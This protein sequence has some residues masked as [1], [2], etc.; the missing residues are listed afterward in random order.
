LS[1]VYAS[2]YINNR[3]KE[4]NLDPNSGPEDQGKESLNEDTQ[5]RDL[6]P[7]L[8][9]LT[10]RLVFSSA[11]SKWRGQEYDIT[12]DVVQE[13][14]HRLIEYGQKA[15]RG[16]VAPIRSY[17][18]LIPIVARNICWD[19]RRRDRRFVRLETEQVHTLSARPYD[20]ATP[21][22]IAANNV[23]REALFRLVAQRI[24]C[25]PA[26]QRK[27]LLTDLANLMYFDEEPTPLQRAFL[28]VGIQLQD[29]QQPLS[30]N[31]AERARHNA[32]LY[33]AYKRISRL[34]ELEHE[35]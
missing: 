5:W 4:V 24:A 32:L 19:G 30:A 33:Q 11:V 26:K 1:E 17:E 28:A 31:Q 15:K 18:H 12:Q 27:A 16:E 13:T 21:L 22:D 7:I 9:T 34:S 35:E 6:Y 2:H 14:V 23:D 20:A 29:Y 25:F 3:E 10:R 8:Q